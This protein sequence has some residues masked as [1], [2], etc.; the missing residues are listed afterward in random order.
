MC[1]VVFLIRAGD[2][3]ITGSSAQPKS[4]GSAQSGLV[5]EAQLAQEPANTAGRTWLTAPNTIYKEQK[6]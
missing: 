6:C 3:T 4:P 2:I 1:V 5:A